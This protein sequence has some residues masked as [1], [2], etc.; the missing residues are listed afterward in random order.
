TLKVSDRLQD[1][2]EVFHDAAAEGDFEVPCRVAAGFW[3]ASAAG[4]DAMPIVEP[5]LGALP[6]ESAASD[7]LRRMLA[8]ISS[9]GHRA[10]KR[11]ALA[12]CEPLSPSLIRIVYAEHSPNILGAAEMVF[13]RPADRWFVVG[14]NYQ[15]GN[16]HVFELLFPNSPGN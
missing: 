16:N 9:I 14:F 7:Q 12:R 6:D 8:S 13:Y 3:E 5:H 1:N 15:F 11:V 4:E 2:R 10:E